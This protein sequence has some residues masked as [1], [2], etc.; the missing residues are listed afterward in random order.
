MARERWPSRDGDGRVQVAVRFGG[1]ATEPLVEV[2]RLVGSWLAEH[3]RDQGEV[4]DELARPPWAEMAGKD[5]DVVF[6]ARPGSRRWKGLLSVFMR[7]AG[8]FGEGM[9]PVAIVDRVDGS[10]RNLYVPREGPLTEMPSPVLDENWAPGE[11][12]ESVQALYR[13]MMSSTIA[14]LLKGHGFRRKGQQFD[15]TTNGYHEYLG[16]QKDR[17][18]TKYQVSFTVNITVVCEAADEERFAALIAAREQAPPEAVTGR[19][20]FAVPIVGY[21]QDRLGHLLPDSVPWWT[22]RNRQEMELVA[23]SVA[24]AI[25]DVAL[26]AM[27]GETAK[28]LVWPSYRI[29]ARSYAGPPS[30]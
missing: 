30:S 4:T 22:F 21:L 23:D 20:I 13:E 17:Y 1:S 12:P 11:G 24:A 28:P 18:N 8:T 27:A 2:Q 5:V 3:A 9:H 19:M 10:V 16:F 6:E 7:W 15:R 29:E 14:P 26:P 25:T